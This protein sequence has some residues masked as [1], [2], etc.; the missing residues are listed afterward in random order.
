M[1]SSLSL[2]SLVGASLLGLLAAS[3]P[4]QTKI[5]NTDNVGRTG[6]CN[7]TP[8]GSTVPS[9]FWSNQKYQTIMA[10]SLFGTKTGLICSLGFTSC[11]TG[12]QQFTTIEIKTN[13][14]GTAREGGAIVGKAFY[15]GAIDPGAAVA[16]EALATEAGA[17]ETGHA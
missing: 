7:V 1:Q 2:A 14:I 6:R 10:S 15:A 4:A 17:L 16:L 11:A 8:F 13:F 9:T 3:A 5:Y 12:M